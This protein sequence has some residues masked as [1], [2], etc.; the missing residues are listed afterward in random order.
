MDGNAWQLPT[1]AL[2]LPFWKTALFPCS[3]VV[4]MRWQIALSCWACVALQ[5][6]VH[7]GAAFLAGHRT[8]H[9]A[10]HV[11]IR[12]GTQPPGP[13]IILYERDD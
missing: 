12:M 1:A 6:L 11:D 3:Q 4:V 13:G 8:G 2:K 9:K 5:R 10:E 7:L